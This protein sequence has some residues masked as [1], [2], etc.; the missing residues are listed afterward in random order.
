MDLIRSILPVALLAA[1]LQ[2]TAAEGG[3]EDNNARSGGNWNVLLGGGAINQARYP[4][5]ATISPAACLW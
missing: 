1:S 5:V 3:T 2:A 4:G